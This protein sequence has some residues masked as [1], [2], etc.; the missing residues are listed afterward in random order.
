MDRL[1]EFLRSNPI[2]VFVL[3]AW[4]AGM[5]GNVVKAAGKARERTARQRGPAANAAPRAP[6]AGGAPAGRR[7]ADDIAAEM[8]R[9]PGLEPEAP[10]PVTTAE[11]P[12]PPIRRRLVEVERPPTPVAPAPRRQLEIHVDP[13][14]GEAMAQ[15]RPQPR[16]RAP[17]FGSLGGR[18]H[19][20]TRSRE[21]AHRFPLDDLKSAFVL[22][23]ILG[24]PVG[25]R[26]PGAA[27]ER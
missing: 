5:I 19:A 10:Q 3:L 23:E 7:S 9:L 11:P 8:R 27:R 14:V 20:P 16:P 21:A 15:R 25:L 12:V 4:L 6:Q 24:P 26:P 1:F 17:G 18:V 2:V 22:S 13:H